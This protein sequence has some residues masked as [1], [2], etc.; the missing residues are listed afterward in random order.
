MK[1]LYL[2]LALFLFGAASAHSQT[3]KAL[4]YNT[5]NGQIV[6]SGTNTLTFTNTVAFDTIQIQSDI[7]TPALEASDGTNYVV[8]TASEIS[9]QG[10]AGPQT[11]TNLGLGATW[12]TNNNVTNF[13][14]AIG[15]GTTSTV[16]FGNLQISGSGSLGIGGMELEA[17]DSGLDF[18]FKR[19]G[20]TNMVLQTNGLVL[21]VGS[22]SFSGGNTN[23]ASTTR[24][25]IGLGATWLTNSASPLFWTN[26]PASTTNSGTSGQVAYTNNYL[27]I[28]ISNNTWR[29]VLLGTW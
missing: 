16:N 18:A 13:R 27:Y 3:L 28:C 17:P 25:N 5:T 7:F 10:I 9:F 8:L 6:Y 26:V 15:L 21:H 12:L 14:T 19:T 11:R 20:A 24:T 1:T 2:I 29:R 4:S 23:G 22:Y